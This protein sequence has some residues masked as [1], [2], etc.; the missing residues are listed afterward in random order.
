MVNGALWV[1][2]AVGMRE[3][4]KKLWAASDEKKE[5]RLVLN[6]EPLPRVV[7]P[8]GVCQTTANKI[9]LVCRQVSGYTKGGGSE[10]YRNLLLEKISEVEMLEKTF[11]VPSDFDPSDG[12]Y[13]DWVYHI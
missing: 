6:G 3:I 8:F 13:K 11:P 10:G 9:A 1:D 2:A 12:Q 5:C 7:Q 4:I